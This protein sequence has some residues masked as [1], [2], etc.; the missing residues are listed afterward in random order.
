MISNSTSEEVTCNLL[1]I[2]WYVTRTSG[3]Y[4]LSKEFTLNDLIKLRIGGKFKWLSM[5]S[6]KSKGQ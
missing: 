3:N 2:S 4:V 6:Q 5:V 1:P